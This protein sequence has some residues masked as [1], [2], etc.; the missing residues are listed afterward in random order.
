MEEDTRRARLYKSAEQNSYEL[1]EADTV[2]TGP[3]WVCTKSSASSAYIQFSV[4]MGLLK[5][6]TSE[7]LILVFFS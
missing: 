7:S 5:V 1:T 4:F 3:T 6:L 2:I